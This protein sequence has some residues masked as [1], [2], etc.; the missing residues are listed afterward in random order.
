MRAW[1]HDDQAAEPWS[2]GGAALRDLPSEPQT[3][4]GPSWRRSSSAVARRRNSR[5]FIITIAI[6]PT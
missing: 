2:G 3:R 4:Y 1:S 5:L 6:V